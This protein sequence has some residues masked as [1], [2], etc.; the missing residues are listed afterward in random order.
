[1]QHLLKFG[2]QQLRFSSVSSHPIAYSAL[3]EVP[4]TVAGAVTL[5]DDWAPKYEE[6][7]ISWGYEAPQ[8][9]ADLVKRYLNASSN[10]SKILD[11][12]CGTGMGGQALLEEGFV[13]A[14]VGVDVSPK[15]VDLATSMYRGGCFVG[16]LE[17]PISDE[18]LKDGLFDAAIC[19]GTMTYVHKFDVMFKEVLKALKP[20]G[21]F[22]FTHIDRY[23]NDDVDGIKTIADK[24]V[25]A[26]AWA[27]VHMSEPSP[28]MPNNPDP[29]EHSKRIYYCVYRKSTHEMS[30]ETVVAE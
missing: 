18:V 11:L 28:Y 3:G 21:T 15:S 22:V 9:T 14:N 30:N 29:S 12:G 24:L 1:M 19:V 10:Q 4:K 26:G 27:L 16:S 7:L 17:E 25:S 2:R 13:G 20:G 23:W 6:T 8:K 5:Y